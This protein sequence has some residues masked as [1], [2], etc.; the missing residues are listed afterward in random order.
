MS[1]Y[2]TGIRSEISKIRVILWVTY[3]CNVCGTARGSWKDGWT[4]NL[5][6]IVDQDHQRKAILV[7]YSSKI[8]G[9]AKPI[10]YGLRLRKRS[11]IPGITRLTTN[12]EKKEDKIIDGNWEKWN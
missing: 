8:K 3:T 1:I 4:V 6:C 2:L 11:N 9:D 10:S 12:F 5:L 7:D